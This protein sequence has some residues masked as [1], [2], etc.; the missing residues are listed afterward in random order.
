MPTDTETLDAILDRVRDSAQARPTET[1]A[2]SLRIADYLDHL[3]A[4]LDRQIQSDDGL[5]SAWPLTA[6]LRTAAVGWRSR[7]PRLHDR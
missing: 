7:L 6:P 3:V 2:L 5:L 4:D 1:L